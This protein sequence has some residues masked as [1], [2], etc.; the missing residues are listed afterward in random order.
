MRE[1]GP[2]ESA[3]VLVSSMIDADSINRQFPLPV[4]LHIH[5]DGFQALSQPKRR[6]VVYQTCSSVERLTQPV[7]WIGLCLCRS[8]SVCLS[9]C[10]HPSTK[11]P[12]CGTWWR[13][14]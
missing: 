1:N 13:L 8:V 9:V 5:H 6:M 4:H 7:R 11:A 3:N 2:A 12:P 10:T 14:G